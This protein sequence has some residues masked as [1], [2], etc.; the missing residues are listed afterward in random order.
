PNGWV[1]ICDARTGDVQLTIP[2]ANQPAYSASLSPN[3]KRLVAV[4]GT[5]NY[6]DTSGKLNEVRIWDTETGRKLFTLRGH[7]QTVLS[8]RYSPDGR[9]IATCSWDATVRLWDAE[10]GRE[11]RTLRGHRNLVN[12]AAF[13][14]DSRRVAS[15]SDDGSARV[16]DADTGQELVALRGHGGG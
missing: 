8:A 3:G 14:P 12:F 9:R 13:S 5:T 6:D 4:V 16:W 11:L 15:C 2:L 10:T 7:T 1:K